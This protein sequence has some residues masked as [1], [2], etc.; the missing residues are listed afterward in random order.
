[1]TAA[2]PV[3]RVPAPLSESGIGKSGKPEMHF[4]HVDGELRIGEVRL[5]D[6]WRL[7]AIDTPQGP[8]LMDAQACKTEGPADILIG[9]QSSAAAIRVQANGTQMLIILD[10]AFLSNAASGTKNVEW[11]IRQA[12]SERGK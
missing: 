4:G 6:C 10:T 2:R 5:F 12:M 8:R 3:K 9:T 1:M 11:L 7:G